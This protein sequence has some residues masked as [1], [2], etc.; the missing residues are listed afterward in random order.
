MLH[1]LVPACAGE[2]QIIA[3]VSR[4]KWYVELSKLVAGQDGIDLDYSLNVPGQHKH[5]IKLYKAILLFE[6]Y[7][8]SRLHRFAPQ[9][10]QQQEF[11]LSQLEKYANDIQRREQ[12]L[13]DSFNWKESQAKLTQLLKANTK[14]P[15]GDPLDKWYV[16]R[17]PEPMSLGGNGHGVDL[18]KL[19]CTSPEYKLFFYW[20]ANSTCRVLWVHGASGAGKTALLQAA[21]RILSSSDISMNNRSSVKNVAY[22]FWMK[23][24]GERDR[25]SKLRWQC[26]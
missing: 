16:E 9:L 3:V 17:Q 25:E 11:N 10:N 4:I 6:I 22:Y 8:T 2:A 21:V 24:H 20:S 26:R 15:P 1:P 12:D 5:I 19:A 18:F 14:K 13:R 23:C 7:V